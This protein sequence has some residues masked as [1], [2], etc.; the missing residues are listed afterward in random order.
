MRGREAGLRG[1]GQPLA[2]PLREE[3]EG[4]HVVIGGGGAG[5]PVAVTA[6]AAGAIINGK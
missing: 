6:G 5:N 1:P 3:M 2:T 4:N